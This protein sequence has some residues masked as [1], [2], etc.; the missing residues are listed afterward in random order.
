MSIRVPRLPR[1]AARV[2][3]PARGRECQGG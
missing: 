3:H 1:H 2:P